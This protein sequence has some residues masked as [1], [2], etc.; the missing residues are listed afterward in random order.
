MKYEDVMIKDYQ[1]LLDKIWASVK[2]RKL[3]NNRHEN[4][5]KLKIKMLGGL[6]GFKV[7]CLTKKV[8]QFNILI[9]KNADQ[10]RHHT[11]ISL[12]GFKRLHDINDSLIK[13][14]DNKIEESLL[15]LGIEGVQGIRDL[16]CLK[17]K[18]GIDYAED[19]DNLPFV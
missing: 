10:W 16:L 1:E 11:D 14:Y 13:Y 12:A 3:V 15:G 5:M 17:D 4:L 19:P 9:T 18:D 8:D 7:F 6:K 2:R